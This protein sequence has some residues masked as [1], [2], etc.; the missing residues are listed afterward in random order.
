M[1][2]NKRDDRFNKQRQERIDPQ[3]PQD[4]EP[5]G[6]HKDAQQVPPSQQRDVKR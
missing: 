1:N 3:R 6:D 5:Q 4:L 2:E